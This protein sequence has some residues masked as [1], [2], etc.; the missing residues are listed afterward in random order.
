LRT[1]FIWS[2]GFSNLDSSSYKKVFLD[3]RF[4]EMQEPRL[5]DNRKAAFINTY[6]ARTSR[7][8]RLSEMHVF[9]PPCIA[10]PLQR[11]AQE[12]W[13]R[14]WCANGQRRERDKETEGNM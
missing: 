4:D 7:T 13:E 1:R 9:L 14:R 10:A 8:S 11:Q 2:I 5:L 3:G 6:P 12:P